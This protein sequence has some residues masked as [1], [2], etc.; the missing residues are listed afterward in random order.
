MKRKAS[1]STLQ[2][3]VLARAVEMDFKNLG[4]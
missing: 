2:H 4:I 1:L 3:A